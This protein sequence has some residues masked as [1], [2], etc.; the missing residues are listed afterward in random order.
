MMLRLI[1]LTISIVY[2]GIAQGPLRFELKRIEKKTSAC[3]ITLEYPEII[4]AA[5][6][7]APDRMNAGILRMLLRQSSW[8]AADSGFRSLDEYANAFLDKC[9]AVQN[10]PECRP[11]Y[12]HHTAT[13]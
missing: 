10:R 6:P 9:A 5:S 4:S 11:L 3:V 8:P 7:Q 12:E 13:I 2:S 1:V